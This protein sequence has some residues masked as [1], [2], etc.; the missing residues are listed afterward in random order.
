MTN[1]L[2]V[3]WEMTKILTD[4]WEWDLSKLTDNWEMTKIVTDNWESSTP[5]RTLLY[6]YSTTSWLKEV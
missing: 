1:I 5:I 6:D 4:S 3:S 2:T